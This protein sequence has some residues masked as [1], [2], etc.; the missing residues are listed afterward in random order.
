MLKIKVKREFKFS[1]A[2]LNVLVNSKTSF[3]MRD[4]NEFAEYGYTNSKI[5]AIIAANQELAQLPSDKEMEGEKMLVT[6]Q[7]DQL[8]D[9]LSL[10]A[11]KA[12]TVVAVSNPVNSAFFRQF[13]IGSLTKLNDAELIHEVNKLIAVAEKYQSQLEA[14]GMTLERI[15]ELKSLRDQLSSVITQKNLA[16]SEREITTEQRVVLA[17]KLYRDTANLCNVGKSIWMDQS[18]AR[19]GDYIIHKSSSSTTTDEEPQ[20]MIDTQ[21]S[22]F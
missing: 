17:N 21:T 20:E 15:A 7:K 10:A 11:H 13:D 5:Q 6:E 16:E 14:D 1:Y 19:Y 3:A 22:L 9:N 12:L 2:E 4:S 8:V 18:E